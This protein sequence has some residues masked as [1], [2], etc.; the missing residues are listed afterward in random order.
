MGD[1]AQ[2]KQARLGRLWIDVV[3]FDRALDAIERLVE[4]GRGG[5]VVTPNSDHLVRAGR[6]RHFQ[7]A[8]RAASLSLADGMPLVWASRL[9]GTPLPQRVSGA[10]LVVPLARRAVRRGWSMYLCGGAPGVAQAAAHRLH[11]LTGVRIAGFDSPRVAAEPGAQGDESEQAVER[12]RRARPDL[13]LVALG[14]PK[15]ELWLHRHSEQLAPA[16][17]LAIG[18]A[19]DFLAGRVRRAPRWVSRAGLEWLYRLGQEPRRLWRRYLVDDPAVLAALWQTR[20]VPRFRRLRDCQP[21]LARPAERFESGSLL[22]AD[23]ARAEPRD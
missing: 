8:Y 16:V 21:P 18:A 20:R 13:L 5:Y 3:D 15:Q 22:G 17:G 1:T 4:A 19:L 6:D 11:A 7:H 23:G 2:W 9:L 10:D 14:S 12:I